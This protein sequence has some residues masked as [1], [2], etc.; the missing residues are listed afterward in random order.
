MYS[1]FQALDAFNHGK[2]SVELGRLYQKFVLTEA[3]DEQLKCLEI[4]Q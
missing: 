1:Q 2:V 4:F 3:K